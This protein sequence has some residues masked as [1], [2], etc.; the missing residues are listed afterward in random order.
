MITSA[1]GALRSL[2]EENYGEVKMNISADSIYTGA[3]GAALFANRD[4]QQVD[5]GETQHASTGEPA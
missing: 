3:L 2:I 1:V 5:S 4:W